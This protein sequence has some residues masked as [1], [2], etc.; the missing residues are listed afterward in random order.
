MQVREANQFL[1][2]LE[3]VIDLDGERR[4]LLHELTRLGQ[5]SGL[6]IDQCKRAG[7]LL[8]RT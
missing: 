8:L 6:Q 5:L 3:Q 2:H 4:G 1:A 7:R